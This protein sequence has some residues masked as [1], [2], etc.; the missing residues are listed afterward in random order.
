M[1]TRPKT[2]L[3]PPCAEG[4]VRKSFGARGFPE[5]PIISNLLKTGKSTPAPSFE[6]HV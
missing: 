1:S 4:E 6:G 5:W 3:K 2:S